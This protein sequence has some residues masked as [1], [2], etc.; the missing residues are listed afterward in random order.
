MAGAEA[1]GLEGTV[2]ADKS[3]AEGGAIPTFS[4]VSKGLQVRLNI[5]PKLSGQPAGVPVNSRS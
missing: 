1:E 2:A 5:L 3:A 4:Y